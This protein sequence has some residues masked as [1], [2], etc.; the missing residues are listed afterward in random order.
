MVLDSSAILAY[1]YG[2]PGADATAAVL[3]IASASSVNLVEV[4]AKYRE[5]HGRTDDVEELVETKLIAE[6]PFDGAQSMEAGRLLSLHRKHNLSLAD[7][8][9]LALTA[10]SREPVMTTDKDWAKLGLSL[11]IRVIR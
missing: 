11:D 7:C 5:R 10:L 3:G 8:A 6:I 1:L 4:R 9:C 2:E